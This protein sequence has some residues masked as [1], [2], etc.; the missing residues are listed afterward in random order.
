[1]K[2]FRHQLLH[3]LKQARWFLLLFLFWQ[4]L[5]A[6]TWISGAAWQAPVTPLIR[7]AEW[8]EAI[9]HPVSILILIPCVS[10]LFL[11]DTPRPLTAFVTTRPIGR[12]THVV[13]KLLIASITGIIIP[14][15]FAAFS[16]F[17]SGDPL[18]QWW[19]TFW[20]FV[21]GF[22]FWAIILATCCLIGGTWRGFGIL[23]SVLLVAH[24]FP[25]LLT[26]GQRFFKGETVG[27][28]DFFGICLQL[29]STNTS[30]FFTSLLFCCI[31]AA[32]RI[33]LKS[34]RPN[35]LAPVALGIFVTGVIASTAYFSRSDISIPPWVNLEPAATAAI[36]NEPMQPQDRPP[37]LERDWTRKSPSASS[38]TSPVMVWTT[39]KSGESSKVFKEMRHEFVAPHNASDPNDLSLLFQN[40]LNSP[41]SPFRRIV[42]STDHNYIGFSIRGGN[43]SNL[44]IIRTRPSILQV[45]PL[46]QGARI[47]NGS[48]RMLISQC[49]I[50]EVDGTIGLDILI[51]SSDA[52]PLGMDN[53]YAT[54]N[55]FLKCFVVNAAERY[56][57]DTEGYGNRIT[58]AWPIKST[59]SIF[60]K[61]LTLV[62]VQ[63]TPLSK[64][65][66][67]IQ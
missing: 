4:L 48:N 53:R 41:Q 31:V 25:A 37:W 62:Q 8:I 14:S 16:R 46:K 52:F 54:Q 57:I 2:T 42:Q 51:K 56:W 26:H 11:H 7:A 6:V 1:M 38:L 12:R 5:W 17:I 66:I 55:Q 39:T 13:A 63:L 10:S 29:L 30:G 15:C 65:V 35:P 9:Y 47:L 3:E 24:S 61:D 32:M 67:D 59:G 33:H 43:T 45:L 34:N 22:S 50:Q 49:N 18:N 58:A 64:S 60:G 40:A 23:F 28:S 21:P 44:E 19:N 20:F 27:P 36:S